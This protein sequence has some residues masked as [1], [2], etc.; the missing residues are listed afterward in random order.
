[1]AKNVEFNVSLL[2]FVNPLQSGHIWH[3]FRAKPH[4]HMQCF[5]IWRGPLTL[6]TSIHHWPREDLGFTKMKVF[7]CYGNQVSHSNHSK[8]ATATFSHF[9]SAI[10]VF[11]SIL[12]IHFWLFFICYWN[13]VS[14]DNLLSWNDPYLV[15]ICRV[16]L[17]FR[18]FRI[19]IYP[20]ILEK[21]VNKIRR[22]PLL[23]HMFLYRHVWMI[24]HHTKG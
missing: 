6:Y 15:T 20:Y 5:R 7:S 18:K 8:S 14:I 3:F 19:T 17:L 4:D 16:Y 13:A 24:S 23:I 1:M 2:K 22:I 12:K 21:I 11:L 9:P 10:F